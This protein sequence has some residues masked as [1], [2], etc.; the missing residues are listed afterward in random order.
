MRMQWIRDFAESLVPGIPLVATLVIGVLA[1]AGIRK[2]LERQ[3]KLETDRN[4]RTQ[5]IML[6]LTFAF[7]VL[8]VVVAPIAEAQQG[9]ILS[10]IGIVVSAAIA[11]SSTTFVGNAMAGLM[12]SAVKGF[13]VGDFVSI[14]DHFGRVTERGLFHVEIQTEQRDLVTLPNLHLVTNPVKVVRTSGTIVA[15]EVSLG[16]DVPREQVKE[17]L[18]Q[19]AGKA[20]LQEPFV[21]VVGLGDFSVIY[22][23]SGLLTEVKQ[24]IS[25]RSRLHASAL[26]ELHAAG[27]EIVSPN[28]MNTRAVDPGTRFVPP[29]VRVPA[30][31]SSDPLPEELVF[32]KADEAESREQRAQRICDLDEEIKELHEAAKA[33]AEEHEKERLQARAALREQTRDALAAT[34][35]KMEQDAKGEE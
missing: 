13:R 17:A 1:L 5:A 23:V 18:L 6:L 12:M 2:V 3:F 16:Y 29:D 25:T 35:E 33:A 19:A 21:Q 10:L 31:E 24:L 4:L 9:Q 15:A 11:L 28:F 32:D 26:D 8:L 27:I 30:S 20:E 7:V 14:G 34:L 22:R